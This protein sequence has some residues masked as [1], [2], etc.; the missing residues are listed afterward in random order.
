MD[1][2]L[3]TR[4]LCLNKLKQQQ[5]TQQQ[6]HQQQGQHQEHQQEQESLPEERQGN[7]NELRDREEHAQRIRTR[8]EEVC[9]SEDET[10]GPKTPTIVRLTVQYSFDCKASS[11]VDR[12]FG[13]WGLVAAIAAAD[14][15]AT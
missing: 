9:R 15:M 14:M 3:L 7:R 4:I 13:Y 12:R 2:R 10:I 11:S 8:R 1:K 6:Q 5:R